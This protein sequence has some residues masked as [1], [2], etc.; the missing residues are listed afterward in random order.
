M[1]RWA[2]ATHALLRVMSGFF[3]LMH[4]GMKWFGWFGG[5]GPMDTLTQVGGV[6]ELVGGA[7][8]L[9]GL[10]TRPAAFI[11]S[12]EMAVAY[13]KFHAPHGLLPIPNHGEP[14][15]LFCFIFLF[16]AANG[17]GPFS[18]DSAR[19]RRPGP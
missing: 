12:G 14:A 11:A 4:G 16:F 17:P 3:F 13:F 10:F 5:V 2:G 8:I 1:N 7:L 19:R 18:L 9:V 6:I 15:A